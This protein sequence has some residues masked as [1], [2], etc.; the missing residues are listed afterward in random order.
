MNIL[1]YKFLLLRDKIDGLYT[2]H[3]FFELDAELD[4]ARFGSLMVGAAKTFRIDINYK[5]FRLYNNHSRASGL[6]D[7]IHS[8]FKGARVR[9]VKSDYTIIMIWT[10]DMTW[11]ADAEAIRFMET[12]DG[13]RNEPESLWRCAADQPLGEG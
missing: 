5:F 10:S 6:R 12:W 4:N 9:T 2:W 1:P 8:M 13:R 7:V 11:L 3:K